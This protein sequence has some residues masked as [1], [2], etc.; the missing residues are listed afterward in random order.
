MTETYRE[1]EGILFIGD[2]HLSSKKP[3]RRKDGNFS[4]TVLKKIE[5]A[6]NICNERRFVPCFLGDM[7]DDAVEKDES[8]KTKL[9]RI[10]RQC[11]TT[12]ISNVGNHDKVNDTLT[13][14]DT[15]AIIAESGVLNVCT[16]AGAF[17]TF[18][19]GD[20]IVGLG[21]TPYGQSFPTDA[22]PFFGQVDQIVWLTHHDVAF[23]NPY[24]GS[25][26]PQAI[27]G[28]KLVVNG[29]MHLRKNVVRVGATVW[30]NPGNIIRQHVDA[31]DHEPAVFALTAK[32]SLEKFVIPHEKIIFDLTG[33]LIDAISPGE[34]PTPESNKDFDSAFVNLLN[35]NSSMEMA[36][37]DDGSI[38][39]EDIKDKF[40]RE[41]TSVEVQDIVLGLL[42][43]T[44]KNEK[45]FIA[46]VKV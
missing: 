23:E 24:P 7:F 3:G 41:K 29:H 35:A 27:I 44:V 45:Q 40:E 6:I 46:E 38:L 8:L 39:L 33:K 5:Y 1:V 18:K 28:C 12:P 36:K 20:K 25:V 4:A 34:A 31:I 13:D 37:S 32:G 15:L 11:W 17:E 42:S 22:R 10:L 26:A 43:R 21:A 19:I 14:S 16:K 30:F 2:P 9:I